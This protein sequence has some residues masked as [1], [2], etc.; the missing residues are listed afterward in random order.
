MVSVEVI[1]NPVFST[2]HDPDCHTWLLL[3]V[4]SWYLVTWLAVTFIV[5]DHP[6]L[7][8]VMVTVQL[9]FPP[10]AKVYWS[11]SVFDQLGSTASQKSVPSVVTIC[12]VIVRLVRDATINTINFFM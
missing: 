4:G 5:Y 9:R 10:A 12:A 2:V 11:T 8:L 1:C 3:L 7:G 6:E